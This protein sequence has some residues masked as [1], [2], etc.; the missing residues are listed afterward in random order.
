MFTHN[1]VELP[2]IVRIDGET[3]HYLTPTGE[4]YPSVTTILSKTKDMTHLDK[5]RKNVG[6]DKAD[7]ILKQAG[8]RGTHVHA[9]CEQYILNNPV[10]T[11]TVLPHNL[12]L[13]KQIIPLLND[14]VDNVRALEKALFSH[15]L[16][17]A[18]STDLI[19][20]WKGKPAII[21]FKTSLKNK[22][23]DWIEDYFLQASMYSFMFWEMTR[24]HYPNIV[25]IIAIEEEN[26]AQVFE[27]NAANW[28]YKAKERCS[29]YHSLFSEKTV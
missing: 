5:W 22:R 26:Y 8:S 12:N 21:D 29:D 4:K 1:F 24:L 17:A 2:E 27:D 15:R 20:D 9:L 25:V 23:V 14:N 16:K 3:R 13:F 11:R 18:G 10:D 6:E 28:I 19:A 7:K